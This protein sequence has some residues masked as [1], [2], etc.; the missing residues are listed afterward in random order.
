VGLLVVHLV[1][2]LKETH[3]TIEKKKLLVIIVQQE[4]LYRDKFCPLRR[5]V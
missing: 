3:V 5:L 4:I 1:G 2:L